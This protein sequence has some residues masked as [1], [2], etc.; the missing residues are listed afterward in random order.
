[1]RKLDYIVLKSNILKARGFLLRKSTKKQA[2]WTYCFYYIDINLFAKENL[3]ILKSFRP[4]DKLMD[5]DFMEMIEIK[6]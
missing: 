6:R 2:K 3:K 4:K 1:M 5:R